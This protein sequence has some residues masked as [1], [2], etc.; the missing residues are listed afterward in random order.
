MNKKRPHIKR[1]AHDEYFDVD[2]RGKVKKMSGKEICEIL[3]AFNAV[4]LDTTV[5][6]FLEAGKVIMMKEWFDLIDK[7][8]EFI[9]E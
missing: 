3:D 7:A 9:K 8:R 4:G 2:I 6:I 1:Y 5:V